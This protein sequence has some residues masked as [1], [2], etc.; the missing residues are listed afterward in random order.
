MRLL[1]EHELHAI[2]KE[3]LVQ[4][5]P[6]F[7][8][9]AHTANTVKDNGVARLH[10]TAQLFEL[11]ASFNLRAGVCFLKDDC[12][13][14]RGLDVPDLAVNVLNLPRDA[15]IPID[16]IHVLSSCIIFDAR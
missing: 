7:S 12:I 9:P 3:A 6:I 5:E 2:C 13:G 16:R 15:A 14:I 8:I 1:Q 11:L 4:G 10:S